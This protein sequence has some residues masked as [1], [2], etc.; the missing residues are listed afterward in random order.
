MLFHWT[1][2]E[3]YSLTQFKH[4]CYKARSKSTVRL[5]KKIASRNHKDHRKL[6]PWENAFADATRKLN[7]ECKAGRHADV[8]QEVLN[9][10]TYVIEP[11][12]TEMYKEGE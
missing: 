2:L 9:P 10:M 4:H 1:C 7:P 11:T 6:L 5:S 8:G 12:R 3:L